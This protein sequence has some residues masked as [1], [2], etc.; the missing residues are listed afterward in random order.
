ME[1]NSLEGHFIPAM[2]EPEELSLLCSKWN[3]SS[4]F[5]SLIRCKIHVAKLCSWNTF[6]NAEFCKETLLSVV[7]TIG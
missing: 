1:G 3:L 7:N 2:M 6:F 4:T 5:H